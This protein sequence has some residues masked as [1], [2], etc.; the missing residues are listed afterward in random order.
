MAAGKL[1]GD[2]F[3]SI[4]ENAPLLAQ[5]IAKYTHKSMGD[6]KQMSSDGE[7]TA[8]I[9]KKAMFASANETNKK[10]AKLPVTFGQIG[11]EAKNKII[12]GFDPMFVKMGKSAAKLR[13]IILNTIDV[14][15]P[16]IMLLY[17]N[18]Q[19]GITN[20]SAKLNQNTQLKKA[21]SV[22][23]DKIFPAMS[24]YL[25]WFSND[26]LPIF[27]DKWTYIAKTVMPPISQVLNY[28][29][30]SV[31][32]Q[33][34][35]KFQEWMPKITSIIG[36]MSTLSKDYI[37]KLVKGFETAWPYIQKVVTL[38]IDTIGGAISGLLTMLEGVTTTLSGISKGD[39]SKA[40]GGL[41]NIG[42]GVQQTQGSAVKGTVNWLSQTPSRVPDLIKNAPTNNKPFSATYAP[43][44]VIQGNAD[45]DRIK[46]LDK[47]NQKD[48]GQRMKKFASDKKRLSFS[49]G[50]E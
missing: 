31:I 47:N 3:R 37:D 48:F 6:L 23:T 2:E 22:L 35:A 29:G 43:Q 5:A 49:G 8:D 45:I 32:P 1:Q 46:E 34:G 39:W 21:F 40:W 7:I 30:T 10:F 38:A 33:L 4:M 50:A 14:A 24:V 12:K 41:Q 44:Y 26:I 9:I 17:N 15:I 27:I 18:I 19:T 36:D 20:I 11:V 25:K 28:I 42:K 13:P 16:K